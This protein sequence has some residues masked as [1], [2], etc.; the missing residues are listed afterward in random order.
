MAGHGRRDGKSGRK[1]G[2]P[3]KKSLPLAAKAQE[4]GVDPFEILLL[5][6]AGDWDKLG[7]ASETFTIY[8]KDFSNEEYTIQPS[9]RAKA[10]AEACQYLHPK[11]K[12]IEIREGKDLTDPCEEYSDEELDEM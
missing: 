7:Y 5:F 9:V 2:S 11:R 4:L 3:N 8:S 12:A 10:A 6:A 1:K